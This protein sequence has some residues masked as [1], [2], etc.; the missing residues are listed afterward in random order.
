M[1]MFRKGI[2][3]AISIITT[4]AIPLAQIPA[5]AMEGGTEAFGSVI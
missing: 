2:I 4:M 1:S 3:F 5:M